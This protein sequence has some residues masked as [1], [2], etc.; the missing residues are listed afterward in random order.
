MYLINEETKLK[1]E[2]I[3]YFDVVDGEP[4][5]LENGIKI[6][7]LKNI[8]S[9]KITT[10]C[11]RQQAK[12]LYDILTISLKYNFDWDEIFRVST[13][14]QLKGEDEFNGSIDNFI[15]SIKSFDFDNLIQYLKSDFCKY[16]END[17]KSNEILINITKDMILDIQNKQWNSLAKTDL[18]LNEAKPFEQ[19][20]LKEK[21]LKNI[22]E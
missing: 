22:G 1:I 15:N 8:L 18:L 6:D 20:K 4:L 12:D 14:K 5:E 7:N 11:N 3:N 19:Y 17:F 16:H 9:S 13:M 2:N 21:E 10:F